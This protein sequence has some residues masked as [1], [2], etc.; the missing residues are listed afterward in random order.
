MDPKHLDV[1]DGE[2]Y[3]A[4][5]RGKGLQ[6]FEGVAIYHDSQVARIHLEKIKKFPIYLFGEVN[7]GVKLI[8][9]RH[10]VNYE[11][12]VVYTEHVISGILHLQRC[13]VPLQ[14]MITSQR[15]SL[16]ESMTVAMKIPLGAYEDLL[17]V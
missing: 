12:P 9:E 17:F 15:T 8:L 5:Y 13:E 4:S 6:T 11:S 7:Q 1:R 2:E 10:F 16:L 14:N 3:S